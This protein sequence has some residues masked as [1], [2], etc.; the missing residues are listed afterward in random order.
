MGDLDKILDTHSL[1]KTTFRKELLTLFYDVKS[2]LTVDEIKQ[3]V[4]STN[5]KVTVYRALEAFQKKGLIHRVPDKNNLTRFALCH[6][7]CNSHHH[8]HHHAHFI[9]DKCHK[10]FCIDG[11]EVPD[12]KN[13]QGFKIKHSDLT[14][15][16]DCPDC[17]GN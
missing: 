8:V 11:I 15:Q 6:T 12:V 9:C 16:G 4:G 10:T 1:R 14:L 3:K 2:S 13:A 7:G 5:D 17:I